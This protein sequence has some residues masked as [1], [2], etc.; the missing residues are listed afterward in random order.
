MIII[1][2]HHRICVVLRASFSNRKLCYLIIVQCYSHDMFCR[3][4]APIMVD[5]EYTV[6]NQAT[7]NPEVKVFKI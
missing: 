7:K 1:I 2:I 6:A 3:Y 4:A 5:V